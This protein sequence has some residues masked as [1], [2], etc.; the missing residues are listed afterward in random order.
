MEEIARFLAEHHPFDLLG[1]EQVQHLTETIQIEY[2]GPSQD[3][4]T[5]GGKPTE[6]LYILRRGSVDLL[7][8][9]EQGLQVFDTLSEGEIFGHPSLIRGKAPIVTVRTREETLVYLLPAPVFHQL[10]HDEPL[11][12]RFFAASSLERLRHALK[13]RHA[14]ASPDLFQLRMQDLIRR[15]IITIAATASVREAAILM[16]DLNVSSLVVKH[17]PLG[18]ITDRDLRN[19]VLAGGLNDT[20]LI[21]QVMTKPIITLPSNSLVFEGLMLMLERGI[22]HMPVTA[23][24][25]VI[26]LVTHTEILRQQSRSPLLLP[27][28]LQRA[29][30]IEDLKIYTQQVTETV[31]SL[32]DSGVRISDLGRVVAL[33]HDALVGRL[34]ADAEKI[35]GPPPC[36]YAWIVLGSEGRYEQTLRTDQDNALIY[37]DAEASEAESYF[38]ALA[39]QVVAWLVQCGFPLCPGEIMATNPQWRQPLAVWQNYFRGWIDTPNENALMRLAIFFD[40]RRLGGKLDVE[41]ALRPIIRRSRENRIFL[42]RMA[43][44]ALRQP[45]PLSFFR[46][47]VLERSGKAR[48]L[49]DLKVRGTALIVDLARIFALECGCTDTSTLARLR[50]A[51]I[52]SSLSEAGAEELAAAFELI[53]LLRLRHQY[54]QLRQGEELTNQVPV[55][56]LTSL[57]QRELKEALWAVARIQRSV[58]VLFQ[59]EL[60]A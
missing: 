53:S 3:I 11:F 20:A 12:A 54:R 29:R 9:D 49:I 16:R 1:P 42:G 30:S 44:A 40:Y 50:A 32:L 14:K 27:R 58:E 25:Q 35:F 8:E 26:G 59:T 52:S 24:E 46:H 41:Q 17:D 19:R 57:E 47:F 5:Y 39:Q 34:L 45:A 15:P 23:N 22:H 38:A 60:F 36:P 7:R 31:G 33:S 56:R 28:Q 6:F 21:A 43:R 10:R 4:M 55:S 18:I 37:A 2:F 51:G 13:S 48:D